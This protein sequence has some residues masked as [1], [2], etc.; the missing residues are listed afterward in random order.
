MNTAQVERAPAVH[1]WRLHKDPVHQISQLVS[2]SSSPTPF[3]SPLPMNHCTAPHPHISPLPQRPPTTPP[4]PPPPPSRALPLHRRI[5]I[6][7][8]ILARTVKHPF[9]ILNSPQRRANRR[10][11]Q[12]ENTQ[13]RR[14]LQKH[15][16]ES[17]QPVPPTIQAYELL[18]LRLWQAIDLYIP[19]VREGA[20][21]VP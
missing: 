4:Q 20:E 7:R 8:Q 14:D 6:C 16:N 12:E 1:H 13:H 9:L 18:L 17:K 3:P 21:M 2:Y 10:C 19:V 15:M 11:K 5:S